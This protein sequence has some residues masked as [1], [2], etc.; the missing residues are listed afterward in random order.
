[1]RSRRFTPFVPAA[2]GVALFA[3]ACVS[4]DEGATGEEA[5]TTS[6]LTTSVDRTPP[7]TPSSIPEG[8]EPNVLLVILDDVGLDYFPGYLEDEGFDKA[9]MPTVE[10]LMGD[11]FVFTRA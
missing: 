4:A 8:A 1:M 3:T 2:V 7:S 10:G 9:N 11:G 6:A 5:S